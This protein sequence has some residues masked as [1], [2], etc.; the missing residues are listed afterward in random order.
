MPLPWLPWPVPTPLP[1]LELLPPA[2]DGLFDEDPDPEFS[3]LPEEFEEEPPLSGE[4]DACAVVFPPE[5]PPPELVPPPPPLLTG[6]D[7]CPVV[8]GTSV[9]YSGGV[10]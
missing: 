1:V 6:G 2:D 7:L 8:V 4:F 9:S 5:L 10:A 3:V